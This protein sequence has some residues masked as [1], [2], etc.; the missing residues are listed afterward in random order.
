MRRK[1]HQCWTHWLRHP[2][3]LERCPPFIL[4]P[5]AHL[6]AH[7]PRLCRLRLR[8]RCFATSTK[9]WSRCR[10]TR[11]RRL[12][13]SR[14]AARSETT[15][16]FALPES[17][18]SCAASRHRRAGL[19]PRCTNGAWARLFRLGPKFACGSPDPQ[20]ALQ[21]R[22]VRSEAAACMALP[23]PAKCIARKLAAL[24]GRFPSMLP[25]AANIVR[26]KPCGYIFTTGR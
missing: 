18:G 2:S 25:A 20:L 24:V 8:L 7:D 21:A 11:S 15:V 26:S 5:S 3:A 14:N 13:P 9:A 1:P 16:A 23:Q 17:R 22:R 6:A 19:C 12:C 4:R 10:A